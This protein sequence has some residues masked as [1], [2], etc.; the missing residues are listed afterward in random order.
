MFLS[1]SEMVLLYS[2]EEILNLRFYGKSVPDIFTR[3][4]F[5]L[6]YQ[7]IDQ[8]KR[9]RRPR[10]GIK[11]RIITYLKKIRGNHGKNIADDQYNRLQKPIE[12]QNQSSG[13]LTIR[14]AQPLQ[15]HCVTDNNNLIKINC[16]P[17]ATNSKSLVHFCL[18]N[19]R[20]INNKALVIKDYVVENDIDILAVTETWL[21]PSDDDHTIE[22]LCPNG[23]IFKHISRGDTRGGGVGVLSKKALKLTQVLT[24]HF[25]SFEMIRF[26]LACPSKASLE[27][28]L[29]YRPPPSTANGLSPSLFLNEFSTLLETLV[30]STGQLLMVGDFNIHVDNKSDTLSA[31]FLDL[32]DSFNLQQHVNIATHTSKHTLDLIITR[33]E[34]NFIDNFSVK[35]PAIS[36]HMALHCSLA[37]EKP[38]H[39]KKVILY[40]KLK[41]IDY[42]K[43]CADILESG[44]LTSSISN[45]SDAIDNYDKILNTVLNRHA[46]L[47]QRV[48]TVRP[49]SEWYSTEISI[50]KAIR[51][52]LERRWRSSRLAVDREIYVNQC[53]HVNTMIYEAKM[54]YYSAIIHDHQLNQKQL[55]KT[56]SKIL[57][58]KPSPKFPTCD[59]TDQLVNS[60]ADYFCDKIVTIRESLDAITRPIT[61]SVDDMPIYCQ[62][63]LNSFVPVSVDTLSSLI[64]KSKSKSCILDPIPATVLKKCFHVLLP[65]ITR[66]VNLSITL[67]QVPVSMKI[68]A[69]SP[70]LKKPSLD[71]EQFPNFRSISNLL[72]LSKCTEKAVAS[73]MKDYLR[74]NNLNDTFQSAY[75]EHHS[76]ETAL[77]RVQND[78]LRTIDNQGCAILLLLDLSA[79]F[80]TVDHAILL[81]RLSSRFGI[82]GAALQWFESYLE[83]RKQFVYIDD[84]KSTPRNLNCG[85]PQGSVLGPLLYLLYTS[86]I[87]DIL[88]KYNIPF[89]LFADDIQMFV[90]FKPSINGDLQS[91][92]SQIEACAAELDCWM[93]ENKLKLN[94]R[95]TELLVISSRFRNKPSQITVK[96]GNECIFPSASAR[97]IGVMFQEDLSMSKHIN[98]VCKSSFY[99][100]RRLFKIRKYLDLKTTKILVHAFVTSKLDHCNSLYLYV[101]ISKTLV[102]KL[103]NV[104][105]AAA[106]LVTYT[107]K[108]EHITPALYELHWLPVKQRIIFKLLLLTFKSLHGSAP[109]YLKELLQVYTP[110]RCLRSTTKHL[111]TV[112]SSNCISY[113]DRAFS[114]AAPKSWNKLPADV[115]ACTSLA[116]FKNRLKTHLFYDSYYH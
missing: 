25:T 88:G 76:T 38:K 83:D 24:R 91:A 89:H 114:V 81:S 56:V 113:G 3:N 47:K 102:C 107:K 73:Q 90:T 67:P 18:L 82:K 37:F 104:Q 7:R 9:K 63:E 59:S 28:I 13:N 108:H 21:K 20:S 62:S 44:I 101:G 69:L 22:E 96:I 64:G 98:N 16:N 66:I 105:N 43:F 72:F 80:D 17:Q 111:L 4:G 32:L 110:K 71:Y 15:T 31:K 116:V 12:Y 1:F 75:K 87:G 51:R 35:D 34:E 68:G 50:Q 93:L 58:S 109:Q 2:R 97:N 115:R 106:R 74:I 112:P 60:F 36:D 48:I 57:H 45:P 77:V 39:E 79:A 86:P 14:I 53:Y 52:K 23:Y 78:I 40:R 94:K 84:S 100:L 41:N 92:I 30:I 46:P 99:H 27:I 70:A 95:K 5:A 42:E 8:S 33:K 103:Q 29:I 49:N 85:V 11:I 61:T 55:F 54:N 65:I 26:N 19:A 10:G 6:Y